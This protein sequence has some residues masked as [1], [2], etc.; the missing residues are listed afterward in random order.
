MGCQGDQDTNPAT[1]MLETSYVVHRQIF[2]ILHCQRD[3]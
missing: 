2:K 1:G 3:S